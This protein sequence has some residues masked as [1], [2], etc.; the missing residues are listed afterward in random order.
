MNPEA[1]LWDHWKIK[2]KCWHASKQMWAVVWGEYISIDK[3]S[4]STS[5]IIWEVLREWF[6]CIYKNTRAK[7]LLF[8]RPV[9]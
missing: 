4:P 2:E 8:L 3:N 6:K 5:K 7:T 9:R 1:R